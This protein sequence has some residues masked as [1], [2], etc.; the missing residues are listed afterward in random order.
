MSGADQADAPPGGGWVRWKDAMRL[1]DDGVRISRY[2]ESCGQAGCMRDGSALSQ[3]RRG[4]KVCE[5]EGEGEGE[6]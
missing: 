5:G 2:R 4:H 3:V 1:G 6:G